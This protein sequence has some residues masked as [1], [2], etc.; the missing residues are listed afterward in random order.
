MPHELPY[1]QNLTWPQSICLKRVPAARRMIGVTSE[2]I[3]RSIADLDPTC[4]IAMALTE[5]LCLRQEISEITA[6]RE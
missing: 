5:V 1:L 3:Q 4:S 2:S 6:T